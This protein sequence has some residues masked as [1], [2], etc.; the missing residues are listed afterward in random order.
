MLYYYISGQFGITSS[1]SFTKDRSKW[2]TFT[3]IEVDRITRPYGATK[4]GKFVMTTKF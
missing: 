1:G 2:I 4:N 3:Q